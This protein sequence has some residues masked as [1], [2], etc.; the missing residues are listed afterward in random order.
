[1]MRLLILWKLTFL[2]FEFLHSR[3]VGGDG[4]AFD[5]NSILFDSFGGIDG[6]LVI[7]L[8]AVF[9]ALNKGC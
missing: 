2:Q 6:D 7:G 3:L 4:G 5:T 9:Q 1:M 8:V